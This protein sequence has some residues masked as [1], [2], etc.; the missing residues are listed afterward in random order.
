MYGHIETPRQRAAHLALLRD[1]QRETGGFTE[2]VPLAFVHS[3]APMFAKHLVPEVPA[4]PSGDGVV[5]MYAV[6]RLMLGRDIPNLQVSW[7]KQGLQFSQHCLS[8]GANDIGGTLINESIS[9]AA[10]AGHGQI[11]RPAELRRMIRE[12][13]R[14]PA[15]RT[16]TYERI[17]LYPEEPV[18][19]QPLDTLDEREFGRFGSYPQLIKLEAFRYNP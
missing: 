12:A 19:P 8:A 13:G 17:A 18:E 14:V 9:T 6:S 15:E 3:E 2:F 7:V 11:V 5:A 16:T 4:G 10:G 1:Q